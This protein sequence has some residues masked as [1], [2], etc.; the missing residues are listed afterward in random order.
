VACSAFRRLTSVT[1]SGFERPRAFFTSAA[2][3]SASR[4]ATSCNFC[5]GLSM[6]NSRRSQSRSAPRRSKGRIPFWFL[7]RDVPEN[8]ARRARSQSSLVVFRRRPLQLVGVVGELGLFAFLLGAQAR[9]PCCVVIRRQPPRFGGLSAKCVFYSFG[10]VGFRPRH[11]AIAVSVQRFRGRGS[12][13]CGEGPPR[14]VVCLLVPKH[15]MQR[16]RSNKFRAGATCAREVA[17]PKNLRSARNF[18]VRQHWSVA[19]CWCFVRPA[20]R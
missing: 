12:G 1:D 20:E 2:D 3:A 7:L 11:C 8:G 4:W 17:I 19:Q 6:P 9:P 18:F 13:G 15:A 10:N 14:P 5:D 16:K